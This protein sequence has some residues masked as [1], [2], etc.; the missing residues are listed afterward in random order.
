M[1]FEPV[2]DALGLLGR[3]RLIERGR[4]VGVEMIHDQDDLVRLAVAPID[5]APHEMRPVRTPAVVGDRQSRKPS[6]A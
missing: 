1:D 5:Q 2:G 6:G 4:G 3:E